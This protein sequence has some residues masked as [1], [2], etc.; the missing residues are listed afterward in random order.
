MRS[1][2]IRAWLVAEI[3][4]VVGIAP[5]AIDVRAPFDS[6]GLS[7]VDGVSLSGE[8]EQLLGCELPPTLVYEHPSIEALAA[9]LGE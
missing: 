3:A 5:S 9:H 8:L 1:D 4:R 2:A 7:S 6:L